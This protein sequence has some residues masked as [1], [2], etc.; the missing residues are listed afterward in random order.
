MKTLIATFL[1]L[2]FSLP[3]AMAGSIDGKGV[4][5]PTMKP[6]EGL[7]YWF[8]DNKAHRYIIQG[9][10]IKT[11]VSNYTEIGTDKIGISDS[12]SLWRHNL[13]LMNRGYA[14]QCHLVSTHKELWGL[15]K[16]TIEKAK[17]RNKI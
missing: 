5:C 3:T 1:V 15:L 4:W 2:L 12:T 6:S 11:T 9:Y 7:G 17:V 14:H 8:E 13:E 16:T 10:E